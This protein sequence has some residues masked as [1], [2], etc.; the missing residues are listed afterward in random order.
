[1]DE[2]I[3]ASTA[4]FGDSFPTANIV[5]PFED[6]DGY[7]V[8]HSD[9]IEIA[10]F[11]GAPIPSLANFDV[12][13]K[14]NPFATIYNKG[15]TY[16]STTWDDAAFFHEVDIDS[17]PPEADLPL[18]DQ[19]DSARIIFSVV[20]AD[21]VDAWGT[22]T[23]PTGTYD[24][25]RVK[26]TQYRHTDVFVKHDFFGWVD[27]ST[28]IQEG[29]GPDTLIYYNFVNDQSKDIICRVLRLKN[30]AGLFFNQVGWW[31]TDPVTVSAEPVQVPSFEINSFPNPVISELNISFT[32]F[33]ID[34]YQINVYNILGR[35]M[36]SD[37]FELSGNTVRTIPVNNL[38]K[39]VYIYNVVNSK[40][41]ILAT[42]K[43]F[44][45]R[46]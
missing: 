17:L 25:L 40:G 44:V 4:T 13:V 15:L 29:L 6:G 39:G 41:E 18:Q 19:L 5:L 36:R 33:P 24:V 32:D 42:R 23:T 1:M 11:L 16:G 7:A 10:G 20:K 22:V 26:E 38:N 46:P 43:F 35:E 31:K 12:L 3:D 14:M 34:Q 2:V 27:L 21:T 45:L 37:V 8:V 28:F 9:S 30:D